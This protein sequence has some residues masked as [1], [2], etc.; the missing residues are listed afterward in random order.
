MS[1]QFNFTYDRGTTFNQ[2]IGMEIAGQLWSQ[3]LQD[4]TT[5]NIH[6]STSSS[7]PQ[8]VIGGALP[9]IRSSTAYSQVRNAL[10]NDRRSNDD[11][12]AT[13]NLAS[14]ASQTVNFDWMT[15]DYTWLGNQS[16]IQKQASELDITNANAKALGLSTNGAAI[17]GLILMSQTA[18]WSYDFSGGSIASNKLDYVST[19]LHE[20][21]HILGFVSGID[22][23]TGWRDV[24]QAFNANRMWEYDAEITQRANEGTILDLFRFNDSKWSN[25]PDFSYGYQGGWKTFS[26]N[27]GNSTLAYFANGDDIANGGDGYQG[28]HWEESDYYQSHSIMAPVARFGRR[29]GITN[30]DR[31]AFDVIGWDINANAASQSWSSMEFQAIQSLA[32]KLNTSTSW[33]QNY[34]DAAAYWIGGD[35]PLA[36]ID[37]IARSITYEWGTGGD[38]WWQKIVDLFQQRS[39]FSTVEGGSSQPSS[40][41][42]NAD[43]FSRMGNHYSSVITETVP[44][45]PILNI[46][47]SNTPTSN[48][49]TPSNTAPTVETGDIQ[50]MQLQNDA[51]DLKTPKSFSIQGSKTPVK[52]QPDHSSDW[53]IPGDGYWDVSI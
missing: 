3:Q 35:R 23:A 25:S 13:N 32:S 14:G 29:Q 27:D 12:T 50:L 16:S 52:N 20:I 22:G 11:Y 15:N 40:D 51:F 2:M 39:L 5:I 21:G 4:N 44:S 24:R 45:R 37:M 1:T 34:Q 47:W 31:R 38:G 30:L 41:V 49:D 46:Q 33:V 48:A 28:S 7:L 17:D 8:G 42:G 19:A 36:V 18:P 26:I 53:G 10:F 9:G 6:V 43:M